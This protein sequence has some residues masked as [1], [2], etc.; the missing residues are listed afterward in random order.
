MKD[1]ISPKIK[2]LMLSEFTVSEK[3]CRFPE[4]RIIQVR[5]RAKIIQNN[6]TGLE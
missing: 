2:P 6:S 4:G 5:A 1:G 3:R